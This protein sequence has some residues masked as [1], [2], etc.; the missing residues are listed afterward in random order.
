[1]FYTAKTAENYEILVKLSMQILA[2]SRIT[3]S[4]RKLPHLE[5]FRP[6][7]NVGLFISWIFFCWLCSVLIMKSKILWWATIALEKSFWYICSNTHL[8]SRETV[9][10]KLQYIFSFSVILIAWYLKKMYSHFPDIHWAEDQTRS[11]WPSFLW[12]PAEEKLDHIG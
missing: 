12:A 1:M 5:L 10:L 3:Q 2:A 8:N 4:Q 9:H 7:R 11:F 6:S